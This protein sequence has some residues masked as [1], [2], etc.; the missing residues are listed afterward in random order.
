M[1]EEDL[2]N[3]DTVTFL[4]MQLKHL[5]EAVMKPLIYYMRRQPLF[6]LLCEVF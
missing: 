2:M 1:N 4:A 6:H 3:E 5:T